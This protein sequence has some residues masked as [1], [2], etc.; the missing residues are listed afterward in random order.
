MSLRTDLEVLFGKATLSQA[1]RLRPEDVDALEVEKASGALLHLRGQPE[2]QMALV[3][4]MNPDTAAALC[5]WLQEPGF[6]VLVAGI[7][8]H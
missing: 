8:R 1:Q 6:W 4:S 5:R 7:T 2:G 3:Q